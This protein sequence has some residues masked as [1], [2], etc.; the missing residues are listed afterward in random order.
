MAHASAILPLED[1][2]LR[3]TLNEELHLR[4][5]PPFSAPARLFQ[6]V[7][8]SGEDGFAADRAAAE[9]LCRRFGVAAAPGKHFI[10]ELDGIHFV[11]ERH[12]EFAS[13]T[14]I[15]SEPAECDFTTGLAQRLPPDWL[16]EVPGRILRAT[17]VVVLDGAEPDP[18]TIRA[19]FPAAD[20]VSCLVAEGGARIWSAFRTHEDGLGRLLI[21]NRS[22]TP[23]DLSRLVQQLQELGNYRNM[24]L[25]GLP[26]AQA[27]APHLSALQ[28]RLGVLADQIAAGAAEDQVMLAELTALSAEVTHVKARSSY[29]MSATQAYAELAADRLRNLGDGRI[30]GFPTLADFTRRRLDPAVRTCL[31]FTRRLDDLERATSAASSLLRTRIET[32]LERQN[33]E[34]LDSMNRR[35]DMQLRLQQTVEGLSVV[36]ISYYLVGLIGYLAKGLDK[37]VPGLDPGLVTAASVPAVLAVVAIFSRRLRRR[38]HADDG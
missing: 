33:L 17:Q 10:A 28:G 8:L 14:F 32:M 31:S 6:L 21:H 29:R 20:L 7:M 16:A 13:Y 11:W 26:D 4:R 34:L 5:F 1:H 38:L 2:P 15:R 23:G 36:A 3:R 35:T 18:A 27:L 9:A 25:L 19:T 22:L 37:L 30:K 12:T 24:A